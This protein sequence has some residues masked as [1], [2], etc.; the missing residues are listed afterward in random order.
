MPCQVTMRSWYVYKYGEKF[1][2]RLKRKGLAV[3]STALDADD[4]NAMDQSR[5]A[6]AMQNGKVKN[7]VTSSLLILLQRGCLRRI[8]P[9]SRRQIFE[10]A[11]EDRTKAKILLLLF[12]QHQLRC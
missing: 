2:D 5:N 10:S 8:D 11:I 4:C 1:K 6:M 9:L 3:T 7:E 12:S